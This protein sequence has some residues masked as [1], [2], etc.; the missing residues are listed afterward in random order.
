MDSNKETEYLKRVSENWSDKI[1]KLQEEHQRSKS[2]SGDAEQ[3]KTEPQ[4]GKQESKQ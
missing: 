2:G 3:V 4:A 1:E